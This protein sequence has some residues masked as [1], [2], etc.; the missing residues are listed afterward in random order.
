M[1][2]FKDKYNQ[3]FS[4]IELD[5]VTKKKIIND[6]INKKATE[7]NKFKC[8]LVPLTICFIILC[9]FL[10]NPVIHA[11]KGLISS[12]T[13]RTT[14]TND[15][16]VSSPMLKI[17]NKS[18]YNELQEFEEINIDTLEDIL[19]TNILSNGSSGNVVKIDRLVDNNGLLAYCQFS[20]SSIDMKHLY[21]DA[22]DDSTLNILFTARTQYFTEEM[23]EQSTKIYEAVDLDA[24]NIYTPFSC[25][26]CDENNFDIII[27]KSK[28]LQ[29]YFFKPYSKLVI[30]PDDNQV[31]IVGFFTYK[32]LTYLFE[33]YGV[34]RNMILDFIEKL[35]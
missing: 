26:D 1:S 8:I 35:K 6:V 20:M 15:I 11:I 14:G 4:K 30:N 12:H 25:H 18:A 29:I 21:D 13:N 24:A 10:C 17:K 27:D 3:Y 23:D 2:S 19:G 33:G 5:D 28:N 16:F 22:R 9:I 34:S 7:S 31:R 32:D